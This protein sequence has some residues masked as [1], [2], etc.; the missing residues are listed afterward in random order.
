MVVEKLSSRTV[1]YVSMTSFP[2]T[3]DERALPS[4]VTAPLKVTVEP[5][6]D[7]TA[8]SVNLVIPEADEERVVGVKVAV[9]VPEIV[10]APPD[11]EIDPEVIV[12]RELSKI[13]E[14]EAVIVELEEVKV[15]WEVTVLPELIDNEEPVREI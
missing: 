5:D 15:L 8:S 13:N 6:T 11:T 3:V 12:A 9:E 2:S 4:K 7:T 10:R 1:L 14:P